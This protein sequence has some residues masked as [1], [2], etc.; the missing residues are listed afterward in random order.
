M[1][2]DY[3]LFYWNGIQ[4]RGEFV[5]LAFEDAG[6]AYDD[7]GRRDEQELMR[8]LE[9]SL[10]SLTPFALPVLHHHNGND[11]VVIA[12][13]AAILHYVAPRI[14]VIPDDE[15]SRMR[16]H[17]IQLTI[18]DL[19]AEVHDTHHPI[20]LSLYYEDQKSEAKKRAHAFVHER[21]PK[22]LRYFE[23]ALEGNAWLV[24]ERCS[25]VDLS[26][27]QVITGLRYAF[28]RAMSVHEPSFPTLTALHD[29]VE[30]RP[31]IARYLAS[32]RRLALND[33]DLFR[34]YPELDMSGSAS[35]GGA[36]AAARRV[37]VK[38]APKKKAKKAKAK[39]R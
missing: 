33:H 25:Y 37:K 12:H 31:H 21:I 36:G 38:K 18:T 23:R 2:T 35:K 13:V 17:Q 15:P 28:P 16:A 1:S 22:Y 20:A 14:G 3:R 6:I 9:P 30:D 11:I 8:V 7:V 19:L 10:E 4:G 27:F 24:G 29:A 32:K 34:H 26:L 5:R 39:R